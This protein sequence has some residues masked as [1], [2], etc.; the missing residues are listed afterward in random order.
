LGV[1]GG[2]LLTDDIYKD[3]EQKK[4]VVTHAPSLEV[5]R[6][7]KEL[8]SRNLSTKGKKFELVQRLVK[9]FEHV[10]SQ[11]NVDSQ[12]IA[13]LWLDQIEFA[14]V[15]IVSKALQ[16]IEKESKQK[17]AKIKG[18]LKK[19]NPKARIIIPCKDKYGNVD[20]FATVLNTKLFNMDEMSAAA[21]WAIKLEKEEHTPETEEYGIS[22]MIFVATDMPVHPERLAKILSGFGDY[23]V[24]LRGVQEVESIDY[25]FGVTIDEDINKDPFLGVVRS[26]GLLWLAN[27]N[28]FPINFQTA[29]MQ[30]H[31]RSSKV[32]FLVKFMTKQGLLQE[33]DLKNAAQSMKMIK[34]GKWTKK[35]GD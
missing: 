18:I 24:A 21:A 2:E 31:M 12:S 35:N 3:E 15:I 28:A 5:S 22:S 4:A 26:K 32:P 23:S 16:F 6:L 29:G 7:C 11:E 10:M 33:E 34:D 20:V 13:K 30:I 8:V 14:N 17:L 19:L 25:E 1:T 27:A 9:E